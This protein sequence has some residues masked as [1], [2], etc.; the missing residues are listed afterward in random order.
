MR[1]PPGEE[2]FGIEAGF[3][4]DNMIA[5]RLE[6][7][8]ERI[9]KERIHTAVSRT[10][11]PIVQRLISLEEKVF[12]SYSSSQPHQIKSLDWETVKFT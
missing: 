11:Q 12:F 2:D 8:F 3:I 9:L 7:P 4:N 10:V 1:V 5:I 6:N